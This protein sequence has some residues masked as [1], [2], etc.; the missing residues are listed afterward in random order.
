MKKLT[1]GCEYVDSLIIGYC[2]LHKYPGPES[3]KDGKGVIIRDLE[4]QIDEMLDVLESIE[5]D[6]N[7]LPSFM[8]QR[9]QATVA[10]AGGRAKETK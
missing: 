6:D 10:K 3:H 1:C 5:N 2:E 9:I 4:T 7:K 8:W